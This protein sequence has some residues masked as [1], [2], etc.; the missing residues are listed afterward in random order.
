LPPDVVD[1]Q[2]CYDREVMLDLYRADRRQVLRAHHVRAVARRSPVFEEAPV[3]DR[4]KYTLRILVVRPRAAVAE[5][6]GQAVERVVGFVDYQR[7]GVVP[8]GDFGPGL[9]PK[10]VCPV[11]GLFDVQ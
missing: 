8:P 10:R 5:R 7:R 1:A 2:R 4:I 11:K 9:L 6:A 3:G